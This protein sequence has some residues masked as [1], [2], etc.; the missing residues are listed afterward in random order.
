MAPATFLSA[1]VTP[2]ERLTGLLDQCL[3]KRLADACD[4]LVTLRARPSSE[5]NQAA[6]SQLLRDSN[7][8]KDKIVEGS[9][10]EAA[11]LLANGTKLLHKDE[12]LLYHVL[13]EQ[14]DAADWLVQ[15]GATLPTRRKLLAEALERQT[16]PVVEWLYNY[17][18]R[19]TL[20][21]AV[22]ETC[23]FKTHVTAAGWLITKY[24]KEELLEDCLL[25]DPPYLTHPDPKAPDYLLGK[26]TEIQDIEGLI[27]KCM[28]AGRLVSM[29]WLITRGATLRRKNGV[30]AQ[31]LMDN[32]FDI[33]EWLEAR[34]AKASK[35]DVLLEHYCCLFPPK[36]KELQWLEDYGSHKDKEVPGSLFLFQFQA[37]H[38]NFLIRGGATIQRNGVLLVLLW[39]RDGD[40]SPEMLKQALECTRAELKHILTS[41]GAKRTPPIV[42]DILSGRLSA[43]K[44]RNNDSTEQELL[45]DLETQRDELDAAISSGSLQPPELQLLS[46]K[47]ANSTQHLSSDLAMRSH[48]ISAALDF[49]KSAEQQLT[50]TDLSDEE[51]TFILHFLSRHPTHVQWD[52]TAVQEERLLEIADYYLIPDLRDAIEGGG[53]LKDPHALE[54]PDFPRIG[55]QP[56]THLLGFSFNYAQ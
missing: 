51:F 50:M 4:W 49:S 43:L 26:G 39:K 30:M 31:A 2:P 47:S 55:K 32:R 27:E 7:I 14:F 29:E 36:K 38:L 45:Q 28:S 42:F 13:K 53:L 3:E 22:L 5:D 19:L 11:D 48:Y 20:P 23:L 40:Q 12:L 15:R 33:A 44:Q 56:D 10:E 24:D 9:L 35:A 37:R 25:K 17:G 52:K 1:S 21:H 34:G 8:L 46:I 41:R 18:A 6:L 54:L 16:M